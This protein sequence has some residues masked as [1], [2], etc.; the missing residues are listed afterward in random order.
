MKYILLLLSLCLSVA[1]DGFA[2]EKKQ[3]AYLTSA[4]PTSLENIDDALKI[5]NFSIYNFNL[6]V[7]S[8]KTYLMKVYLEEYDKGMKLKKGDTVIYET[9]G[10]EAIRKVE[11]KLSLII[12]DVNDTTI[13]MLF[14]TPGGERLSPV[15]KAAIYSIKHMGKIFKPQPLV[16]DKKIPLLLYGSMW[17]DS[18]LP[19]GAVRFCMERQLAPDFSS[20]A[21][22]SMPHYYLIFV[23]LTEKLK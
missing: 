11:P 23:E 5:L 20:E 6:P 8:Q 15:K 17:H 16:P 3:P 7:D 4:S 18:S 13:T 9:I 10:K 12:R 19:K 22:T 1:L 14:R 21:F 2:Q